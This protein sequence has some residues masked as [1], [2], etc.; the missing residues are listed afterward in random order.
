[1]AKRRRIGQWRKRELM[2]IGAGDQ[3]WM[4]Y[5]RLFIMRP[6][7]VIFCIRIFIQ[8]S[9]DIVRSPVA[10][11]HLSSLCYDSVTLCIAW[12]D[13]GRD[14]RNDSNWTK[15]PTPITGKR[16]GE[17]PSSY[18]LSGITIEKE[19]AFRLSSTYIFHSTFPSRA[20]DIIVLF[21]RDAEH[22]VA[23]CAA[24]PIS[25]ANVKFPAKKEANELVHSWVISSSQIGSDLWLVCKSETQTNW[26]V[27]LVDWS[28]AAPLVKV[29]FCR[30]PH[31]Y[32]K[33][34]KTWLFNFQTFHFLF[35]QVIYIWSYARFSNE[36]RY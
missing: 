15:N 18:R 6:A 30:L 7:V 33:T 36:L 32:L 25:R 22:S 13:D 19:R 24:L 11:M 26:H 29:F 9:I 21:E 10:R 28:W 16:G 31:N 2:K 1:M 3:F 4:R 5:Y 12:L 34:T 8:R 17:L 20:F 27:R 23:N 35:L 14:N